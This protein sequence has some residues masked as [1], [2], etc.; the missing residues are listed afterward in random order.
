MFFVDLVYGKVW[1]SA[2]SAQN[3]DVGIEVKRGLERNQGAQLDDDLGVALAETRQARNRAFDG[4]GAAAA[5]GQNTTSLR[6]D[7]AVSGHGNLG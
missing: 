2:S 6:I 3:R 1:P 5:D 4:E 7:R